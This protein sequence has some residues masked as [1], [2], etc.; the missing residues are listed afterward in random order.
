M[1]KLLSQR[2]ASA[3]GKVSTVIDTAESGFSGWRVISA[4]P[5]VS[6]SISS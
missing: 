2:S 1:R 4:G 5:R 3:P 6:W